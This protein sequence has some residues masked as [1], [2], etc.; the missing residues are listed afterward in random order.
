VSAKPETYDGVGF[1][2]WRSEATRKV[3]LVDKLGRSSSTGYTA[4]DFWNQKLLGV[5]ADEL[6]LPIDPHDTRVLPIHPAL[7]RPQLAGETR[8]TS[9]ELIQY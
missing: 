7:N 5:F 1:T 3:S 8:A 4:F 2:N 9:P 6:E